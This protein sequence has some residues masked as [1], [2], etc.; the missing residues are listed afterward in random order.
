VFQRLGIKAE[1]LFLD[2][3]SAMQ[4]LASGE[5]AAV[6]RQVGKPIDVFAKMPKDSCTILCRSCSP[7]RSP[8]TTRSVNSPARTTRGSYRRGLGRYDCGSRGA[9]RVQS[10]EGSDRYRRVARMVESMFTNWEKFAAA[11]A[12]EVARCQ[13]GSDGSGGP[14][15]RCREML[16]KVGRKRCDPKVASGDFATFLRPGANAN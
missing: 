7:R 3:P 11:A 2:N 13:S 15:E 16:R 5:I 10:A 9:R 1:Q 12:S 8:T 4:K 6:M 14:L